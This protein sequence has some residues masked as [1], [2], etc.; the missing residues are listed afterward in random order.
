MQDFMM[1]VFTTGFDTETEEPA[2]IDEHLSTQGIY[3]RK[4]QQE[5]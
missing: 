4:E 2:F 1:M 5:E 3:A